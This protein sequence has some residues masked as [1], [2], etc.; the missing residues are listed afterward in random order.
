MT[1]YQPDAAPDD[2]C[3]CNMCVP[4]AELTLGTIGQHL[5]DE[6]GVPL[7]VHTWPDGSPVVVDSTLEPDDFKE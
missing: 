1:M 7:V 5:Q 4:P 3:W 6:H 2:P